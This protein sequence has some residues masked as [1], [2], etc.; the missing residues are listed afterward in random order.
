MAW[1]LFTNTGSQKTTTSSVSSV[2]TIASA[3]TIAVTPGS[4]I[5]LTGTTTVSTITGGVVGSYITL[6]ASGQATNV[7]VLLNNGTTSNALSLRDNANFGIYAGE[8]VTCMYDGTKWLETARNIK[9][10]LA[11]AQTV[12]D[13]TV[14]TTTANG[15]EVATTSAVTMDG[16]TVII[17]ELF[18]NALDN[19]SS[20]IEPLFAVD[21]VAVYIVGYQTATNTGP[22][23]SLVRY[24]PTAGSHTFGFRAKVD[25]GTGL[26][27]ATSFAPAFIRI[28]RAR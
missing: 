9:T 19:G 2:S 23:T 3:S 6:F 24:T 15:N 7:C 18:C 14:T 4:T 5:L 21:G 22:A 8:S 11:Y 26:V 28:S 25:S 12:T 27:A 1:N 13:T 20:W 10:E 16:S 17:A